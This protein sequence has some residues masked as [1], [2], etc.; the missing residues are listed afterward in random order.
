MS[1]LDKLPDWIAIYVVPLDAKGLDV[2]DAF[3]KTKDILSKQRV[4]WEDYELKK[5][6]FS[7]LLGGYSGRFKDYF[8]RRLEELDQKEKMGLGYLNSE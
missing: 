5:R 7:A 1:L 6:N 2:E 3:C 4:N 8:Q